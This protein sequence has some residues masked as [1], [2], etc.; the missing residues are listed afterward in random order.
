MATTQNKSASPQPLPQKRGLDANTKR[1]LES[2][3]QES[4]GDIEMGRDIYNSTAGIQPPK[5]MITKKSFPV[6]LFVVMIVL[7][8]LDIVAGFFDVTGVV[9]VLR[10]LILN[11]IPMFIVL[12]WVG[13]SGKE[14]KK[15]MQGKIDKMANAA[16]R[17]RGKGGGKIAGSKKLGA[18]V[19]KL[20]S[21]VLKKKAGRKI[22]GYMLAGIVPILSFFALW[23]VFVV[24]FHRD[25]NRMAE[26]TNEGFNKMYKI[27]SQ[28]NQL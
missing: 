27:Q 22:A 7:D 13:K 3:S 18:T 11:A 2:V 21:K 8:I 12:H 20:I 25:R 9:W 10:I 15:E 1:R 26:K 19:D 28:Q 24:S 16:K 17:L 6:V 5:E 4:F 14:Y 23:S